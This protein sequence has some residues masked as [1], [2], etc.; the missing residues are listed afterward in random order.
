LIVEFT[1][2]SDSFGCNSIRS[3]VDNLDYYQSFKQILHG[4]TRI[5][6]SFTNNPGD[7]SILIVDVFEFQ[8]NKKIRYHDTNIIVV[9]TLRQLIVL[10]GQNSF[11]LTKKYFVFSESYWNEKEYQWPGFDYKLIYTSWE[12]E[13]IKNRLANSSNL[14]H[15]L[16]DINI[17]ERYNPKYDF[18]C[19]AG[20]GKE[21]RDLFI[22]KLKSELDLSNSLTSYFGQSLGNSDLLKLDIPYSRDPKNFEDEFYTEIGTHKHQYVLS[23]FTRPE[24]FVQSKFSIVVETE[25]ENRE[26]HITEKTLKCLVTGHPFVVIG[27][28][29]YLNFIRDMGFV[30]CN[31]LFPEDYDE[32]ND[33]GERINAVIT[34][35]KS[36][37]I[38]YNFNREDLIAM[39]THNLRNLFQLKN[40]ST[41]DK[42]L[43]LFNA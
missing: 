32:I 37:Q 2:D 35:A 43:G 38:N 17:P 30:T 26:Y 22:N 14:Y 7:Q 6:F 36:L 10:I 13:D 40:T 8:K 16:L 24:L 20:R 4:G 18:L 34:L 3:F 42:F 29:G 21:W 23:Y 5:D 33:L 39:Q 11:D 12:I 31:H 19:L 28:P 1:P 9:E 15:Y 27:T 41:Y 25:A